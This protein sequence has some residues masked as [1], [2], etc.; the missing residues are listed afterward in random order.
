MTGR[1]RHRV[2]A[3]GVA[4]LIALTVLTVLTAAGCS[5]R[6]PLWRRVAPPST[7]LTQPPVSAQPPADDGQP[8]DASP[9]DGPPAGATG[10][11]IDRRYR[12]PLV[13]SAPPGWQRV[14]LTFDAGWEYEL[15][16]R[17]LDLLDEAGVKATFF[18]RGAWIHD[19]PELARDI[20][21]RG[22]EVE[23][24]SY[25]HPDMT[26]LTDEQ[27]RAE[28]DQEAQ[29][30]SDVL[31]LKPTFFRPPFGAWNGHML[32]LLGDYGFTAAI[33]WTVDTLDWQSPGVETIISRAAKAGDGAIILMHLGAAQTIDALPDVIADLRERGLEPVTLKQL[34]GRSF[35]QAR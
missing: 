32:E 11:K 17:L 27:V 6:W 16:P 3:I 24:H 1:P 34:L 28:L 20:V 21:A 10:G 9:L 19:H 4:C 2:R 13:T 18:L 12:L 25:T 30:F 26:T 5:L 22:H 8:A 33:M 31:S 35:E 14:A 29:V 7:P 15:T 23:S